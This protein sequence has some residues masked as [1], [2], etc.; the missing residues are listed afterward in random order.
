MDF[1]FLEKLL[2]K[3][4]R[5]LEINAQDS[6]LID[7]LD[8]KN[9]SKQYLGLAT[10]N[11]IQSIKKENPEF[12]KYFSEFKGIEQIKA[13][14]ADILILSGKSS[15]YL[16]MLEKYQHV[17]YVFVPLNSNFLLK[18]FR[19]ISVFRHLK[20][21]NIISEGIINLADKRYLVFRVVER[22]VPLRK[23]YISP[24]IGINEFFKK[25]KEEKI[26]YVIL[27]WFEDLPKLEEGEDID[28]LISDDDIVKIRKLTG[29]NPGI[30]PVDLF[31]VSGLPGTSFRNM[32]YYPPQKARE[33]ISQFVFLNSLYKI[34]TLE[35][36]FFSLV[37]HVLYHKGESSGL[38]TSNKNI[39]Q[40]KNPEHDYKNK[41]KTIAKQIDFEISIDMESLDNYLAK[42]GWQPPKDM[43]R[44]ISRDNQWVKERF[45]SD[46]NLSQKKMNGLTVFV[47]RKR[48]IEQGHFQLISDMIEEAGFNIL[49]NKKLSKEE[50]RV[51][52]A[53][54]RG[55]NWSRGP[56]MT[57]GGNPATIIVAYDLIPI[58]PS[59]E[60][61][62]KF[63]HL[64]NS[65]I[66]IKQEIR[67]FINNFLKPSEKYNAIHSSD[68][69]D[70]AREYIKI[71]APESEE[72]ILD[73]ILNLKKEFHH[74]FKVIKDLS[75]NS[76]R[77]KVELIRYKGKLAVCKTF[78]PGREDFLEREVFVM[79]NF[80]R[81][82]EE[83]P[84]ILEKG[85][86]YIVYPY[87]DNVLKK[88]KY[89]FLPLVV[90]KQA[91][92]ILKFF[93]D[94]GYYL[95]DTHYNNLLLDKKGG[96]KIIDFEF[97]QKYK[98]KPISFK[99]SFDIAGT[100]NKIR[101]DFNYFFRKRGSRT[102]Q[103]TW[104]RKTGLDFNSLMYDSNW[105]Q[106]LKRIKYRLIS[107]PHFLKPFFRKRVLYPLYVIYKNVLII[108]DKILRRIIILLFS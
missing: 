4:Y 73:S 33:I 5:L 15:S 11:K 82:R 8:K 32:A 83:I 14:N 66:L 94:Q 3:N 86:N 105:K 104:Q 75:G 9:F 47:I 69:N 85:K 92:E 52:R 39:K 60:E 71:L 100:P 106:H 16:W 20:R 50:I 35:N 56:W 74:N 45:F 55:G 43:L 97:I 95:L 98:N 79:S 17:E 19:K 107:L 30:I 108:F 2:R 38:K 1:N 28:I 63:H 91:I 29:S 10:L 31:S 44:R 23:L 41:I 12:A 7:F 61:K 80:A 70:E 62:N 6:Y 48:A 77:A 46:N 34:P 88:D 42:N 59:V 99:E 90:A 84:K 26:N 49:F 81:L 65:R 24:R 54:L 89:S 102:Y 13:N 53:N 36:Y 40:I 72:D 18:F 67:Y 101:K 76:K 87:Y 25:V 37:Y 68:N 51:A 21:N 96:L 57:S 58:K 103:N 93:Y 27:R 64:S 22:I 78:R